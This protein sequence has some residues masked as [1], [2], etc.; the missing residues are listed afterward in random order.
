MAGSKSNASVSKTGNAENTATPA[1]EGVSGQSSKNGL[2]KIFTEELKDIYSAEKQLLKALPKIV[3]AASSSE[4]KEAIKNHLEETQE[5]AKRIEQVFAM[6]GIDR[7]MKT[8]KAMQG[9]IAEGDD[10]IQSFEQGPVRDAALIIGSQKIEHY[11]IAAYGSLCELA[12]VMGKH[13]AADLLDTTLEEEENADQML[14][15]ISESINDAA[16]EAEQD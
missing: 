16:M 2:M 3:E 5:Q 12:E 11:E 15:E 1:A 4:L 7:E 10:I 6:L 13:Q 14:T 8:C 9:L